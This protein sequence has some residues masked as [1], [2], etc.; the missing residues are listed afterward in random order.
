MR[1]RIPELLSSYI[2]LAALFDDKARDR[3][4]EGDT[5]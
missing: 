5:P 2:E 1:E 3:R 4:F